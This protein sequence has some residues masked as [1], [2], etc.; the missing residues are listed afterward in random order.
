MTSE[1][2]V[3]DA[4][5]EQLGGAW[6]DLDIEALQI[7]VELPAGESLAARIYDGSGVLV[8][9]G[10]PVVG[11]GTRKYDRRVGCTGAAGMP[12]TGGVAGPV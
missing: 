11:D 1:A 8:A 6:L 5:F 12:G 2:A 4:E 9:M 7:D 3:V 10:D